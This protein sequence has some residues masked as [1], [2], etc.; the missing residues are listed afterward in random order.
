LRDALHYLRPGGRVAVVVVTALEPTVE[1]LLDDPNVKVL[2]R[3]AWSG[4]T[5]LHYQFSGAVDQ[6]AGAGEKALERGVYHRGDMRLSLRKLEFPIE[7]A[8]GLPEFDTLSYRSQLLL[9]G[10]VSIQGSAARCALL[11]NP[12]QGHVP[13]AVWKLMKPGQLVLVDRDLLS[14]RYSRNNLIL[15]KCPA[16]H[17]TLSHQ[18]GLLAKDQ[19]QADLIIGNLREDEGPEGVALT[20]TQAAERLAPD[21]T[22]LVTASSTAVT[23]LQR[24]IRAERLL[25][26]KKRKRSK[27]NSLLVLGPSAS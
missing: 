11:F 8:Y 16:S 25:R 1:E 13:V 21:G 10:V 7:T 24:L 20:M 22:I 4:H 15:N 18:V 3:R 23:R 19:Q 9:E 2:F 14:L 17:V 5:V 12:G 6:A 26:I 27:G